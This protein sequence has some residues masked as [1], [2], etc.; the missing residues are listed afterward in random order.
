MTLESLLALRE[1]LVGEYTRRAND[2]KTLLDKAIDHDDVT[3][4]RAK[5]QTYSNATALAEA[6]FDAAFQAER[7]TFRDLIK[8]AP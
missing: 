2:C 4:L 7:R 6:E 5:M 8:D 1:K 3:R